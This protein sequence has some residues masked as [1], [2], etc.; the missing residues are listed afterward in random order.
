MEITTKMEGNNINFELNINGDIAG[1][2]NAKLN[3]GNVEIHHTKVKEAYNGQ[4][5][6][7]KLVESV[8]D[9]ARK[10]Q[11]KIVS[12]CPYAKRVLEK[13]ENVKDVFNAG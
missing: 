4:G 1:E 7:K 10:H 3:Q 8:I 9:Y 2:I 6:G 11:L 13:S 5:L 12:Y